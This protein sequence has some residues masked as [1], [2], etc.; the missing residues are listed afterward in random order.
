MRKVSEVKFEMGYTD[1]PI[2]HICKTCRYL[3]LIIDNPL[4]VKK[5]IM[6]GNMRYNDYVKEKNISCS[7]GGFA[8]KKTASCNMWEDKK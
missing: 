5:E 7:K 3:Y 4:W 6:K 1:K 2:F 8:V